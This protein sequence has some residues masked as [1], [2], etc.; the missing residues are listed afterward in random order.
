MNNCA[1]KPV[2]KR[3]ITGLI[4]IIAAVGTVYYLPDELF[5]YFVMLVAYFTFREYTVMML[6]QTDWRLMPVGIL[7]MLTVY[8]MTHNQALAVLLLFGSAIVLPMLALFGKESIEKKWLFALTQTAGFFYLTIPFSLFP[9]L[10]SDEV[11]PHHWLMFALVVPWLCDSAAYFSG[12]FFGKHKFAPH[13]SPNKTWEGAVGGLL[14]GTISGIIWSLTVFEGK[15]LLF[16]ALTAAAI[17]LFGQLGDL[18][19]S[20]LKRGAGVKDSGTLF[21]GHGGLLDRT[22][23][24]LYSVSVTWLALQVM[25]FL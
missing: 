5:L 3:Y 15:Y 14:I 11:T 1:R 10:R 4:L 18:V 23:S 9:L 2:N 16:S 17:S 24:L 8:A 25:K 13:I 21:P 12:R 6:K 7:V 20:L 19:E 22:D